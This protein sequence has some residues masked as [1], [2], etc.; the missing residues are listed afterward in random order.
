[1]FLGLRRTTRAVLAW[2]VLFVL[3][4]AVWCGGYSFQVTYTRDEMP[5]DATNEFEKMDW[6]TT[7]FVG[8]MFLY[9]F[10]GFYDAAWQTCV[11]WSVAPL[12]Y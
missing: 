2:I 7:G 3:T 8:P 9:I 10:Y 6:A 1:M 12:H 5:D 11:Y 4:L